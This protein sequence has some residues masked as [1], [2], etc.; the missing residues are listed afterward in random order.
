MRAL[1][2]REFADY[3]AGSQIESDSLWAKPLDAISSMDDQLFYARA[4]AK[5]LKE[6]AHQAVDALQSELLVEA[7]VEAVAGQV[8]GSQLRIIAHEVPHER[9]T[10]DEFVSRLIQVSKPRRQAILFALS[11][12]MQPRGRGPG[13][14]NA[15]HSAPTDRTPA[16]NHEGVQR[17]SAPASALCV[18]G[19]RHRCDCC[20]VAQVARRRRG[21]FA[22]AW[23]TIQTMWT[24]LIWVSPRTKTSC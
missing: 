16:R 24:E 1:D 11:M 22:A 7:V 3:I 17:H 23:P 14:G 20:P 6:L 9:L 12:N 13:V 5:G 4:G 8:S 15:A 18:L 10:A 19:V 21:A 2:V